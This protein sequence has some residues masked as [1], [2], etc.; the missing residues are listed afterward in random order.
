MI[1][2]VYFIFR[3]CRNTYAGG[4]AYILIPVRMIDCPR[5][6]GTIVLLQRGF[7]AGKGSRIL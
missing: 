5:F 6:E 2:Q 7:Y 4:S 3:K 1:F